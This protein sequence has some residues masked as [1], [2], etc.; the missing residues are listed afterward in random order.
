MLGTIECMAQLM[1]CTSDPPS[2]P[3]PPQDHLACGLSVCLSSSRLAVQV[4]VSRNLVYE[5]TAGQVGTGS[6][7]K[8]YKCCAA[9]TLVSGTR[10]ASGLHPGTLKGLKF[11]V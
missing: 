3:Y 6:A 7:W 1:H 2:E 10:L 5:L 8:L 11:F 4:Q 9:A